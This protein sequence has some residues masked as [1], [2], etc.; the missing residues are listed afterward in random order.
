MSKRNDE[1]LEGDEDLEE[2]EDLDGGE[3]SW[4]L[5]NQ[6]GKLSFSIILFEGFFK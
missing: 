5:V 3:E 4:Q 2:D 1:D 6:D